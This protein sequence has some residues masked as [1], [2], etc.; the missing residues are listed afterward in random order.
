M[1]QYQYT[2]IKPLTTAHLAQT[3]ALLT[4]SIDEL[5][6]EI[7]AQLAKNPAL[8]IIEER[9]CPAC[10]KRLP[11]KGKCPICSKPSTE[12][13][14]E[15][16]VF[17][18]PRE[19]FY[20][21]SGAT[22]QD[23]PEDQ[24]SAAVEELPTYVL[25]QIAPELK[26]NER[27]IAAYLLT[28]LDE[29]GLL[30]IPLIEAAQYFHV[31]MSTMKEIQT[32]IKKADPIGVG[33]CSTQEAMLI[34]LELISEQKSIPEYATE[35]ITNGDHLASKRHYPDI[36]KKYNLPVK[37]I[38]DI[39]KFVG[40][41]LNPFPARS[42]WGNVRQP[43]PEAVQVYRQPDII[44]SYLNEDPENPLSV[45][46]ILPTFGTLQVNPLFKTSIKEAD[47]EKVDD[48]KKDLDK[49][50]LFVK[51]IQQRYNT[52]QRLMQKL[53][54]Y[55]HDFI[56]LG[57]KYMKPITRA[58]LSEELSV[59]ESTISRAVANKT[60]QLPNKK[61]IPLAGFF[62][63]SLNVRSVLKEIIEQE[64]K[65]L[66]DAKLVQSLQ[67][68]GYKVARRTIAKYRAMEGLL[69]AHLRQPNA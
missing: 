35:I 38:H 58:S 51:C 55:Q 28:H 9:R 50:S 41:N 61:I 15:P 54:V 45:E 56:L 20:Q 16:V 36:A 23:V 62:D 1:F 63:R 2:E 4:L 32:K 27:I 17:L 8:E 53:V 24:F 34:Q 22:H 69:P 65:P 33:S 46:I 43:A 59:H 67:A 47:Q 3:M 29:D 31:P 6:Q 19:D 57:D 18:S 21:P 30:S 37:Q 52:I 68:R 66:S 11:P 48:W 13:P 39:V 60:I 10:H 5:Q 25:R 7:D 49:A 12:H 64:K 14:D 44:I 42:Y 40:E 26:E